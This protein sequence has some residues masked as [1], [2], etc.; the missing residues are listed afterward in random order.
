MGAGSGG[1]IGQ[2]AA[3][4]E[5][6]RVRTEQK[7]SWYGPW[8]REQLERDDPSG[9]GYEEAVPLVTAPVLEAHYYTEANPLAQQEG[10][11]SYRTS[12]TSSGRRKS[13]F[14]SPSDEKAYVRIK[15]EV[16]RSILGSSGYGRALA[17]MGTGH[18]E[19]TAV[20]VFRQL[21]MEVESLSFQLPVERHI[22]RLTSFRPEVLYTM[23]SILDRILQASTKPYDYG[24]RH[25]ILVGEI[26]SPEWRKSVAGR[27]GL[28]L[29]KI[30]DT[31]GSIEIGTIAYYDHKH[32]RYL[33]TE[34]LV[35]E[36]ICIDEVLREADW[37]RAKGTADEDHREPERPEGTRAAGERPGLMLPGGNEWNAKQKDWMRSEWNDW[38]GKQRD[39]ARLEE[40]NEQGDSFEQTWSAGVRGEEQQ[41]RACLKESAGSIHPLEPQLSLAAGTGEQVLVLTS[42]VRDAFPALR[43]VTYDVVRDLR[44]VIV[45]GV[46]RQSFQSIVKR[47]G[48]DLKHGEKISLFDIEEVVFRHLRDTSIQV[49]VISNRLQVQL[50]G[51]Q[52][53]ASVLGSIRLDLENRIPQIGM[54]IRSGL[55]D[56]IEV[57]GGTYEDGQH[58]GAVKGKRV[59]YEEENA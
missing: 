39:G 6:V 37:L 3:I 23:P 30:T 18:A 19:A 36:G 2:L 42:T 43:Y 24:I 34:G 38:D 20:D 35:A 33:L 49:K 8:L 47:V 14:Y 57:I 41:E 54:M 16:F 50:Y 58:R 40:V 15:L 17:D 11:H 4:Q 56:G 48:P 12:G 45:D 53:P 27:M 44:T 7:F 9:R 29:E 5:K 13:I 52:I 22:E 1:Q 28:P 55:L 31:Y 21:G 10:I 32:G 46:S 25:V 51:P 59:I 26:A